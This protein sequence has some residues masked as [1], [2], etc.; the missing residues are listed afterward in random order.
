MSQQAS[1]DS[2]LLEI[3]S[4]RSHVDQ[5]I[6]AL[7]QEMNARFNS[8]NLELDARFVDVKK[9]FD[10]SAQSLRVIQDQTTAPSDTPIF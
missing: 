6:G 9:R 7:N 10:Q 1:L 3:K 8:L 4:L 2:I 5:R